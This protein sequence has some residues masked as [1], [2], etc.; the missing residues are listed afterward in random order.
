MVNSMQLRILIALPI[1]THFLV[2]SVSAKRKTEI[3]P[4]REAQIQILNKELS[5]LTEEIKEQG[6]IRRRLLA[7]MAE[8][9]IVENKLRNQEMEL[10]G[11]IGALRKGLD[12][13]RKLKNNSDAESFATPL[14]EGPLKEGSS[15]AGT[16]ISINVSAKVLTISAPSE[17]GN[18]ASNIYIVGEKAAIL[19]DGVPKKLEEIATFSNATYWLHPQ[20]SAT[21][22]WLEIQ[23]K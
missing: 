4:D 7:E 9:R 18:F 10:R 17:P 2:F 16:I 20:D 12:V 11:K 21:I 14:I 8:I 22:T 13:E 19:K 15:L 3:P 23:T 6:E 5:K 1:I